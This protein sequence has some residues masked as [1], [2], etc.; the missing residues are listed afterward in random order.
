MYNVCVEK[1]LKMKY[2]IFF[3]GNKILGSRGIE[4]I[5]VFMKNFVFLI[6]KKV[7]IIFKNGV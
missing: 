6:R 3:F 2:F 4:F 5:V 1:K 7:F